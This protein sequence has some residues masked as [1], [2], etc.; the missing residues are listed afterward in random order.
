MDSDE[1]KSGFRTV[2]IAIGDTLSAPPK[3]AMDARLKEV[4]VLAVREK[5]Q[6][7]AAKYPT[8]TIGELYVMA[9]RG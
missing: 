6:K 1:S 4:Q 2:T 7:L 8:A 3:A 5:L 9:G